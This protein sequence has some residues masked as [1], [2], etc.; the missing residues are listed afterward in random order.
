MVLEERTLTCAECAQSFA[1]SVED[2]QYHQEKGYT[3]DPKRCPSCRADRRAS[4]SY[5]GGMTREMHPIVCA[6]C[7]KDAEVPFRP[8]GSRPVYCTDCYPKHKETS[9]GGGFSYR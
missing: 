4:R 8:T 6:D 9:G 7:G 2:Q 3:N 1:F 5:G